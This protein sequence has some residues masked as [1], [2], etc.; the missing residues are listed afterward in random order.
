MSGYQG[1]NG[2]CNPP[3]VLYKYVPQCGVRGDMCEAHEAGVIARRADAAVIIDMSSRCT[4]RSDCSDKYEKTD[5]AAKMQT[6]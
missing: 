2:R 4:K 3:I 1:S 6:I 5:A